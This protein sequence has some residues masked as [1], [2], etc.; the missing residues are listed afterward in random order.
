MIKN[1]PLRADEISYVSNSMKL[2]GKM[3]SIEHNSNFI[4][5]FCKRLQ[6]KQTTYFQ[7]YCTS[8]LFFSRFLFGA[9]SNTHE[10][11]CWPYETHSILDF[12]LFCIVLIW[13]KNFCF[14]SIL[15][16]KIVWCSVNEYCRVV[17]AATILLVVAVVVKC[18]ECTAN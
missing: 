11:F 17:E 1:V 13:R 12:K 7:I 5:P 16:W 18:D 9:L 3:L 2:L 10:I 14:L 8:Q 6:S 15:K 4:D